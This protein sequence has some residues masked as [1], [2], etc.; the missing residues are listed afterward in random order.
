MTLI[1]ILVLS[2]A[3]LARHDDSGRGRGGIGGDATMAI[4]HSNSSGS[5]YKRPN[6]DSL[7][8]LALANRL[9]GPGQ[10]VNS[11]H[12]VTTFLNDLVSP[13]RVTPGRSCDFEQKC[14][15]TWAQKTGRGPGF[16]VTTGA[17]VLKNLQPH[18]TSGPMRDPQN[19]TNEGA[20]VPPSHCI[21]EGL[22][23]LGGGDICPTRALIL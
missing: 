10:T 4:L 17:E 5:P 23:A 9:R 11:G 1:V 12:N 16:V 3:C 15:W 8:N 2:G 14:D 21:W 7:R 20:S 18:E 22:G 6:R 19:D 13:S